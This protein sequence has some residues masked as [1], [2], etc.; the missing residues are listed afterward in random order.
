MTNEKSEQDTKEKVRCEICK[1]P[2]KNGEFFAIISGYNNQAQEDG[3]IDLDDHSFG[4]NFNFK[5]ERIIC[6]SCYR[7]QK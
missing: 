1:K 6:K 3:T 7:G 2:V 4:D 5:F